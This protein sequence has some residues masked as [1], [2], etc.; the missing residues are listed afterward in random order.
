M[1]SRRNRAVRDEHGNDLEINLNGKRH[2]LHIEPRAT[3]AEVLRDHLG[4]TGTKIACNRG[5]CGTCTVL[6]DGL[7]IYSCHTLALD[8]SGK[9]VTT[10]EGL[11]KGEELH[12]LQQAFVDRDGLQC[13]YCTPGQVMAA[14]ALL[15][16]NPDPTTA[17]IKAGMSGN[18][19]RCG[20]YPKI[21]ESI[22]AAKKS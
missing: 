12:P 2:R 8:A 22:E 18:L 16:A 10:V 19:C 20:A 1:S 4:L 17:E 13:G 11:M 15:R 14:E 3:L 6:L 7:A 9:K 21:I 5:M